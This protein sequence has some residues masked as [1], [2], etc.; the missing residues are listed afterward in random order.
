MLSVG[1]IAAGDGY[2][3]LTSQVASHDATRAG[4]RLVSYYERTGMPPGVWAGAQ[5][6]AFGLEGAP[7]EE[8]MARLYGRCADP[9]T[10]VV[11]G[12]RM[13]EFRPLAERI[14]ARVRALGRTPTDDERAAIARAEQ[15]RGQPQAV[16]AFDLTFSA[17][18]SVSILW[19]LG[20]DEIRDAVQRAHE[21]AWRDALAHFEADVACTRLGA[22]G[23]AQVDVD[24]VTVAA[25]EHWFNR[26]GDPQLHTHLAVSAMVR[27][28]GSGRWRRLDSRAMYRAA[29]SVGERYTGYLLG[30][31]RDDLGVSV[32]HRPG[33]GDRLL[34]E[35]D[36]ISDQLV[37]AF[38][39]RAAQID[40]TLARLVGE[41]TDA[42]GHTP[43][44]ATTA[45]LAQQAALMDRPGTE[46]RS[47]TAEREQWLDRAG[48]VLGVDPDRVGPP[49]I[50]AAVGRADRLPV[51]PG[52]NPM[53]A[54]TLISRLEERGATWNRR[55]VERE[56]AAVLREAGV[57]VDDGS[58]TVLVAAVVEHEDSV[59]LDAP[60]VGGP[61]PHALR[62]A[63]GSSVFARRGEQLYTST[64]I[65]AAE[66][67]LAA[68]AAVR[69]Q[70]LTEA[71]RRYRAGWAELDDDDLVRRVA[72]AGS[73]IGE[74]D[75]QICQ[76]EA[77][78]PA[79]V[80]AA[81]E[82]TAAA[83]RLRAEM[84]ATSA[85]RAEV[86]ADGV[87]A[88]RLAE[89]DRALAVRGLRGPRGRERATLEAQ[90]HALC[91]A[92]PEIGLPPAIRAERVAQRL[93]RAEALDARAIAE[94]D[95]AVKTSATAVSR[96]RT[97]LALLVAARA[98]QA[99]G[100]DAL[101]GELAARQGVAGRVSLVG[102]LDGLGV[103]QAAA[104][105]RLADPSAPLTALVG[106][107]GSGKTTALAAL[108]RAHTDA[109]RAVHVLAPTAVAAATLGDAVGVPGRTVAS[110]L[111]S[112]DLGRD[113]PGAGDLIL[114][115][116]AS[117]ATTLD[118]RDV[119]RVAQDHGALV[120]LIGDPR[121]ARAV[122]AG[123]ALDLVAHAGNAPTL[124]ELHRFARPWE[125]AASLR[126]R[127]GDP[128]VIDVY[129]AHGRVRSGSFA[130]MLE[131]TYRHYRDLTETDPAGVVMIVS[132]NHS[133]QTLS[134]RARADRVADGRV[135][136][137][138]VVLHDGSVAGIGD[139]IVTRRNDRQL[140]TGPDGFV[141][142]RDRWQVTARTPD[143]TLTVRR[144]DSEQT[145]T[146]PAGYVAT[147][148]ELSYALTG[149]GA[150]GL[151]VTTALAM[152]QPGDERS[153]AYV[154]ATRGTDTNMIRVVTETL[155]DEPSGHHPEQSARDVLSAVLANEPSVTA[156]HAVEAAAAHEDDA[157][158]LLNRHRHTTRTLAEQTLAAVLEARGAPDLLGAPD[159]W[160]LIDETERS[161]E[162]G[163]DPAA[164]LATATDAQLAT[165]DE[166]TH[167]LRTERLYP[168]DV[169]A[170]VPHPALV[171]GLVPATTAA[172]PPDVAAYLDGLTT[173]LTRR[174]D[175]LAA[176][177]QN[178]P[179]PAWA[180]RLG[181][182]PSQPAARARWADNVAQV[183]LWRE[184]HNITTDEPLGPSLPLG[185]RDGAARGRA[186]MAAEQAVDLARGKT[187][188][189]TSG[190][191]HYRGAYD[192]APPVPTPQHDRHLGR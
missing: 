182:P 128:G 174:R 4:E 125:A 37:D 29:A 65:L 49:V 172:T 107:A 2:R 122:G 109:G 146:L 6:V 181:Q 23:V 19:A 82:A 131:D 135:E 105:V 121:Q 134:E 14:A 166:A 86:A 169:S 108:V 8:Q 155:D 132:D 152:V 34:P 149:Y 21:G 52:P 27:P 171:A 137:G 83:A 38:S 123:G 118:V 67:E 94:A 46:Q 88:A 74:L 89:I 11:L 40:A 141:K 99:E 186:A 163:L 56:A 184:A 176:Q 170:H 24:G 97:S 22:A 17:P 177:Y 158:E 101:A 119:V 9:N 126:L 95:T 180:A 53:R 145:A 31:L 42:H 153:F 90:A 93:H 103:D 25:F 75:T 192:P 161:T 127:D 115:D 15:A 147:H 62:R 3:Y 168:T 73:R 129:A 1:R 124:T 143:G 189:R 7:T 20:G 185:H 70:S 138:G 87:A 157:A 112:W 114:V 91:G 18:K 68:L 190:H 151:T 98:E 142:N 102:Y 160:R 111:R 183:A 164:I 16:T 43:D 150:Q 104:M 117:M 116:E 120:R 50:A 133:A 12:R 76:A 36:G 69:S 139:V 55:D 113:L 159:A 26:S 165:V 148:V 41:F 47:W 77:A 48:Q 175:T 136:P 13:A 167:V 32:R 28:A 96:H 33:R 100:R 64:A 80:R 57:R 59:S 5:A 84:P 44:R 54:D 92:R 187:A 81:G 51:E 156:G 85:V 45:R 60:D 72:G 179:P 154:A 144:V 173:A 66:R 71:A 78:T 79:L 188:N 35:L 140:R 110:A 178:G 10:G 61:V 30:R 130:A 63:D 39:S 162:R 106:P 58:V 191:T